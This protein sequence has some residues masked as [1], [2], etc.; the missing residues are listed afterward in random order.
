VLTGRINSQLEAIICLW[1]RGPEGQVL[2]IDALIDTGFSGFL[3]LPAET[4]ASLG[5]LL[6]GEMRGTLA[7]GTKS[8]YPVY[9]AVISWHGQPQATFVS[10]VESHPLLGM[11]VLHGCELAMQIVEGGEVAIHDLG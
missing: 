4:I 5:L 1:I 7:D 10:A 8:F 11:G 2:E 9:T 3:S 6:H